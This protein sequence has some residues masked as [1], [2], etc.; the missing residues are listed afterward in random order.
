MR[1]ARHAG[2]RRYAMWRQ[3]NAIGIAEQHVARN[4]VL[5]DDDDAARG[6]PGLAY[7]AQIAPAVGMT[8]D[9]GALDVQDGNVGLDGRDV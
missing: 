6:Q 5:G 9:V 8:L 7:Q 3:Q 2:N 1:A 4:D